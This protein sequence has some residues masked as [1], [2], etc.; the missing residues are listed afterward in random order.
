VT[1]EGTS[2]RVFAGAPYPAA[3]RPAPRRPWASAKRE[4]QRRQAGEHQ[5]DHS[6]Y[7]AA[8]PLE[9]PTVAL[10]VIVEN[11]G[12]GA[13]AAAPIAR[14]VFDYLLLGQY[15]S[16][17]DMAPRA[18]ASPWRPS[19]RRAAARRAAARRGRAAGRAV[20]PGV[21][22]RPAAAAAP[23]AVRGPARP[24]NASSTPVALAA[25]APGVQRLRRPAVAAWRCCCWPR[26]AWS[27]CTRPASTTAR[28]S[29]TTAATC[30]WRWPA[31][32]RGAGAAAEAAALAVPL[33]VLGVVLLVAPRCRFG[34]TK[35]GATR[36]LNL[37]VGDPAQRDPE[38]RHAADAGLVVP[39]ARGQLRVRLPGAALLLVPVAWWPS[40]PTWAPRCWSCSAGCT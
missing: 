17:E 3:A 31:V 19:A 26:S 25:P 12:F 29:S 39:E 2:A 20:Q 36:W 37:G 16:E 14:R 5:R 35:K 40:S 8:A 32:R 33:Y 22:G 21:A 9:A 28:A 23:A 27:R 4:V 30:C 6:L 34:I 10:A 11:A 24:M 15:P 18:K 38:D 13:E 7:I 1:Q